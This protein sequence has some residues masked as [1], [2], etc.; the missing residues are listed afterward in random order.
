MTQAKTEANGR[1]NTAEPVV[2]VSFDF[3]TYTNG[4]LEDLEEL[5]GGNLHALLEPRKPP[6]QKIQNGLVWLTMRRTN[7]D[8]TLDDVR[9][10]RGSAW[11]I[12]QPDPLPTG[13]AR[14]EPTAPPPS[15][16]TTA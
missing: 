2:Q 16:P 6:P 5:L 1:K 9:A 14:P 10:L 12:V 11:A 3:D 4:E 7:P 13:D 8:V 15:A